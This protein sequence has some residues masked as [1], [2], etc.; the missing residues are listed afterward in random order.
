[1][2]VIKQETKE[3]LRKG[4]LNRKRKLG[5]INSLETRK[6]ISNSLTGRK[7][8][9][10]TKIKISKSKKGKIPNI[11]QLF[12]K[13]QH[14]SRLTEFKKGGAPWNVGKTHSEE[15][16]HKISLSH[17]GKKHTEE[18]LN[19]MKGQHHSP[20]TEFKKGIHHSINTEFKKGEKA[21]ENHYNWQGGKSFE[22]YNKEFNKSFKEQIK[23]RDN[24]C[25]ICGSNYRLSVHHID[26]NKLNSI[27]E[28]CICLCNATLLH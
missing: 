3:K 16:R 15:T 23:L 17:K 26:Y 28:N 21:L 25:V 10:E 11:P 5:Y 13:G 22:P 19:K 12:K 7:L 2:K 1:M 8:S 18:W 6:K 27:K 14:I 24:S 4:R 9:E 20:N